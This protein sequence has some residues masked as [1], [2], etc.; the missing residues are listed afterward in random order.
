[1]HCILQ[2]SRCIE[3]W[4]VLSDSLRSNATEVVQT[5]PTYI[6][7]AAKKFLDLGA[8]GIVINEQLPT[9]VWESG[10]FSYRSPIFSYYSQ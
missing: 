9:N 10:D 5:F 7:S 1:M 2:V 3:R 6:K 8:A 4:I